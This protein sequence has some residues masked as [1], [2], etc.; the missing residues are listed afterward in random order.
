MNQEVTTTVRV[1]LHWLTQRKA[2]L[3][4][5]EYDEFQR[6]VHGADGVNLYSATEQQASKVRKN[7]NPRTDTTQ[8]V[9]L[10]NGSITLARS[11]LGA[12]DYTHD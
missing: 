9:V 12:G 1:R 7:K 5:R 4:S 11:L 2:A 8:P 10:R 6:A 3:V